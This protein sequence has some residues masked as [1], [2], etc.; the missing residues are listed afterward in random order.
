[1]DER[2]DCA[3]VEDLLAEVA[4]GAASGPDRARV[5]RHLSTCDEC[6]QELDA[7]TRVADDVLLIAPE[8]E[9]PAGF[10]GAVLARLTQPGT[11]PVQTPTPA[12]GE[13]GRRRRAWSR[14]TVLAVAAVAAVFGTGGAA[15]VWQATGDDRDL[16]ASYRGTLDVA[17][18]R[19]FS[20]APL[21]GPEGAG[22]TVFL[23][24]GD[25]SWL[26]VVVEAAPA[27]TYD[28][29]VAAEGRTWTV[30]SCTVGAGSGCSTG[31]TLDLALRDLEDVFLVA[32]DGVTLHTALRGE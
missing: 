29:V 28:V 7:L 27:G 19:Y 17:N 3:G 30:G 10:E 26:F 11:D 23:Y 2:T 21:T 24:D 14:R 20:A 8:R 31:A 16:A 13:P 6:R 25:P 4:T 9:A 12:V 32:A 22:G 5:L 1:M 18:G 15:V